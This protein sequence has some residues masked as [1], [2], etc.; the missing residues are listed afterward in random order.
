[1]LLQ[2]PKRKRPKPRRRRPRKSYDTRVMGFSD[3]PLFELPRR[4][5]REIT[6]GDGAMVR[7]AMVLHGLL[8]HKHR[9]WW[10]NQTH[11]YRNALWERAREHKPAEIGLRREVEEELYSPA[12]A[13][14]IHLHEDVHSALSWGVGWR[15]EED[16][17]IATAFAS[18][19]LKNDPR[20]YQLYPN[21]KKSAVPDE[22][23]SDL[24]ALSLLTPEEQDQVA[25]ESNKYA[26][27]LMIDETLRS[28]ITDALAHRIGR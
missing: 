10:D 4:I 27:L 18:T 15:D 14:L 9:D 6:Q 11:S 19:F 23:L 12:L 25:E 1:M 13:K 24:Y 2:N 28:M 3:V 26:S 17:S 16:F 8:R 5:M 7:D 21:Y 22:L 20:Y